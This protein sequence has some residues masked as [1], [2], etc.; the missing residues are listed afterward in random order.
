MLPSP[1]QAGREHDERCH[2]TVVPPTFSAA[3]GCTLSSQLAA[4]GKFPADV[5]VPAPA[6]SSPGAEPQAVHSQAE[7]DGQSLS[8]AK[9]YSVV[10]DAELR[11]LYAEPEEKSTN[12]GYIFV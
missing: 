1:I 8:G 5:S 11:I 4:G 9:G 10:I 3:K 12:S 7:P 2:T 6:L